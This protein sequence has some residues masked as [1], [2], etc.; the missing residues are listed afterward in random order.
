MNNEGS[1]HSKP[2]NTLILICNPICL[3]DQ[4]GLIAR[5]NTEQGEWRIHAR[6]FHV[7]CIRTA[8]L[9]AKV[10]AKNINTYLRHV[11]PTFTGISIFMSEFGLVCLETWFWISTGSAALFIKAQ[12]SMERRQIS[13]LPVL[14]DCWSRTTHPQPLSFSFSHYCAI[15]TPSTLCPWFSVPVRD[16]VMNEPMTAGSWPQTTCLIFSH[17]LWKPTLWPGSWLP[18]LDWHCSLTDALRFHL[19]MDEQLK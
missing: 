3:I 10:F 4:L 2:P 19:D 1:L 5:N 15:W 6:L 7:N 9:R 12:I 18:F 16:T 17:S 8:F 14:K 13:S 11:S